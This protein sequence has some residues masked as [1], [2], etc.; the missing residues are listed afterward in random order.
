MSRILSHSSYQERMHRVLAHLE[1]R[2]DENLSL[3][4][5]AGLAHFSP[6]HF[7]RIFRGMVGEPLGAYMRRLRL[8]RAAGRL[9]LT[10]EGILDI[11]LEAGFETHESFTRAFKAMFGAS[12]S[13]Y[14]RAASSRLP[15]P[16]TPQGV[17]VM[18]VKIVTIPEK[19][20]A[21]VR[22][23]GPYAECGKAWAALC[24]WA[25]PKGLIAGPGEFLG[26][27]YDDPEVTP[28]DRIRYD[29]SLVVPDG[30]EPGGEVFIQTVGGGDYAQALVQG[31]YSGLAAAYAAICGRWAPENNREIAHK[32]SIEVY[33]NDPETTPV[34]ELRTLIHA[35][36]A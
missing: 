27:C 8:E 4:E 3:E 25:G 26:I 12:P 17:E 24:A 28:P 2:L 18:D 21:S 29:A 16:A 9:R 32:P 11:A 23:I 7:H 10:R 30:I 15:Q 22:H 14:R 5:L 31:P 35:P 34:A 13:T 20:V 1:S 19:R 36:L 33:L 6:Y